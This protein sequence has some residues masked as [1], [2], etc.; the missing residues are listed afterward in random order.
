[1]AVSSI[2]LG[3]GQK[4]KQ[5]PKQLLLETSKLLVLSSQELEETIEEALEVNPFLERKEKENL[6]EVPSSNPAFDESAGVARDYHGEAPLISWKETSRRLE[7]DREDFDPTETLSYPITLLE[8][9]NRQISLLP[10]EEEKKNLARW[11]A[12]NLTEDGLLDGSLEAISESYGEKEL[13]FALWQEALSLVQGLDPTGVAATTPLE[14]LLLQLKKAPR[15]EKTPLRE[16]AGEILKECPTLLLRGNKE[17]I[18]A[19]LSRSTAEI[20]AALDVL[21]TLDP[22]PCSRFADLRDNGVIAD[23]SIQK[24]GN[25]L[26]LV[27]HEET[28]SE[29]SFDEETFNLLKES[30]R[31]IPKEMEQFAHEA[32]LFISALERRKKTLSA[33]VTALFSTQKEFF[34]KGPNFLRPLSMQE[35]ADAIGISKSTVSRAVAGKFIE[36]PF[37]VY[38]LKFFFSSTIAGEEGKEDLAAT[39]VRARIRQIVDSEDK[40]SPLS[41]SAIAKILEGEGVHVARRT[42]AKYRE[43]EKIAPKSERIRLNS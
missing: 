20:D 5:I 22:K 1:M 27:F 15:D 19:A 37:G 40:S 4:Q 13:P 30:S 7:E 28:I 38:P 21:K 43:L 41:D 34:L 2:R 33:V 16:L 14:V 25:S 35:L 24:K 39:S 32:K 23:F 9:L 36:T 12:G 42:I 10:L 29:I 8:H 18:A 3:L 6:S 26:S 11:I 31:E 17:A